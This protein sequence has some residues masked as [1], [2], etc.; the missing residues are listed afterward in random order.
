[1]RYVPPSHLANLPTLEQIEASCTPRVRATI[2]GIRPQLLAAYAAYEAARPDTLHQLPPINLSLADRE[3]LDLV[4]KRR[5][6]RFRALWHG[7]TDHFESTGESTCPYCNFGEQWEHDHYLPKSAFPE[8]SLYPNNL[9]PIC[10]QCNGKKL[11]RYQ[12]N[13][14]RL[15]QHLFSE[16]NGV[17][18]FLCVAIAYEP[19]LRV[20]YSLTRPASLTPAQFTVLEQHFD[21]LDLADRYARQASTVLAKLVRQ[22]RKPEN[23]ALGPGH[24]RQRLNQMAVDRTAA[25]PPHHWEAVLMQALAASDDFTDHIFD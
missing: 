12:Q 21:K 13:G 2:A 10:K 19:R 11:A 20:E 24:L 4:F 16:L 23:L 17:V 9:V 15:F 5:Y 18:G 7:L 8:F 14:I 22:F 1:M 6:G 25:S 3:T